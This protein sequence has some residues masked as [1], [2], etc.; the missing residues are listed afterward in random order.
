MQCASHA[1]HKEFKDVEISWSLP[2]EVDDMHV[3]LPLF[4]S[5]PCIRGTHAF[6]F[7][8]VSMNVEFSVHK[9]TWILENLITLKK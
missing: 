4:F 3:N 9:E 5:P 7:S 6:S 2:N 8:G 1:K